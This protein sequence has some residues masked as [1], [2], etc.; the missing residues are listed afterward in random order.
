MKEQPFGHGP[1]SGTS[2]HVYYNTLIGNCGVFRITIQNT[3]RPPVP[4]NTPFCC[5]S[6]NRTQLMGRTSIYPV[7]NR[8]LQI[9]L[10]DLLYGHNSAC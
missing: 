7:K 9:C 4:N 6:V 3:E 8:N 2:V 5:W 10:P 1:E